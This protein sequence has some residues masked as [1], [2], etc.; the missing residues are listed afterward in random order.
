MLPGQLKE[1][2]HQGRAET[3]CKRGS[4]LDFGITVQDGYIGYFWS[5][6]VHFSVAGSHPEQ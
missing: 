1:Q 3:E 4:K 5:V 6:A 2:K